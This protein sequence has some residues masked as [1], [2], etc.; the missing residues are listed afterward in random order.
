LISPTPSFDGRDNAK[1]YP[2]HARKQEARDDE[3]DSG[4]HQFHHVLGYGTAGRNGSPEVTGN[5]PSKIAH[6]LDM[7]WLVESKLSLV[8]SHLV[9]AS[10]LS[11]RSS[12][13]VSRD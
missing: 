1:D 4:R 12:G 8:S 3:F 10:I 5:Q 13:R 9:L 11:Q 2:K 6:K 7:N